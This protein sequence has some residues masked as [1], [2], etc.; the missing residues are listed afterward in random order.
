MWFLLPSGLYS[1]IWH[2]FTTEIIKI[3][4]TSPPES[5]FKTVIYTYEWKLIFA[6]MERCENFNFTFNKNRS[7]ETIHFIEIYIIRSTMNTNHYLLKLR[8]QHTL[9]T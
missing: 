4:H 5:S 6:R 2:N 8:T 3:L 9:Y 1:I 7:T